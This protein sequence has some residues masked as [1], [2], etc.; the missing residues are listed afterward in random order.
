MERDRG[1]RVGNQ[2][3]LP[4]KEGAEELCTWGQKKRVVWVQGLSEAALWIA[5]RWRGEVGR[6]DGGSGAGR[7]LGP[8]CGCEG[9]M[10][11]CEGGEVVPLIVDSPSWQYSGWRGQAGGQ[12]LVSACWKPAG[13]G[14]AGGAGRQRG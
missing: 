14:A 4:G 10:V 3:G 7:L 2:D 9:A 11:G 12:E 6:L 5:G 8:V 13:D 1:M